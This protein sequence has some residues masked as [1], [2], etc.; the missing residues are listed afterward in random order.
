[1][2]LLA[3]RESVMVRFRPLLAEHGLTEQQ[4]RVIRA[5]AAAGSLDAT[6]VADATN[7]L[8][9]SITRI[10][11]KLDEMALV[12]RSPATADQ[13]RTMIELSLSGQALFALVAPQSE[14]IY[15]SIEE[16]FGS[17]RLERLLDELVEL[18]EAT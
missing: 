12:E 2:A 6:G 14:A 10:V 3:A 8:P 17:E 5:L 4:W 9:P 1:M 16:S 18:Q 13:R 11:S 15:Q 7:L